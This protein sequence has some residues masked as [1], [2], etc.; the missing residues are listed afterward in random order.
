ML[1]RTGGAILFAGLGLLTSGLALGNLFYAGVSLI[2]FS[3]FLASLAVEPP[4]DIKA[5]MRVSR[6]SPRVGEELVV[7]VDYEVPGGAGGVEVHV[8]LPE[9]FELVGGHNVRLVAKPPKGAVRGTM[10]FTCRAGKRGKVTL[11]PVV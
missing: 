7:D 5:T 4:H 6:P 9:T 3:L 11:G 1:T 8:K 10:S 2:P